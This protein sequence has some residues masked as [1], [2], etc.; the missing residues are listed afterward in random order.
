MSF[1][2][3][4]LVYKDFESIKSLFLD[5]FTGEP[6]HDD[7]SDEVQLN[8]YLTDLMEGK[9]AL[10]L[11]LYEENDLIGMAL[12]RIKH[13]YEGTEYWIDELG[14]RKDKQGQGIG[15]AFIEL[16]GK[17]ALKRGAKR[18]MLLTD[19]DV[20]AYHF[21]SKCGFCEME[22]SVCFRKELQ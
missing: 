3:R 11:G 21:Y 17:A 8:A 6:W 18:I 12:G 19:R 7:W 1:E 15:T 22:K 14:I 2:L 4:E 13:W 16:V 20:P 10:P 9:N 5:I